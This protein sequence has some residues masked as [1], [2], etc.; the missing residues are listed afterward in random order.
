M[1]INA[2]QQR[3][4]AADQGHGVLRLRR[5]DEQ[6]RAAGNH[7]DAGRDHRG[8]VDQGADGR[9][10]FH[11]V[12]Q[13][14]MQRKLGALAA[15]PGQQQQANRRADRAADIAAAIGN[16]QPRLP[17][18]AGRLHRRCAAARHLPRRVV[19]IERAVGGPN[20]KQTQMQNRNRRRD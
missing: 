2:G 5:S 13:P 20:Q 9:G 17:K 8:R 1:A 15:G 4:E 7:V 16:R 3:R 10:A 6:R 14:D 19:K 12:G 18:H 11:R